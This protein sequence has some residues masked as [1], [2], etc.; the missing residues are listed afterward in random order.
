MIS[1]TKGKPH[2]PESGVKVYCPEAILS[3]TDGDQ[4]P[5]TPLS[6]VVGSTGATSPAQIGAG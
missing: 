5:V 3:T 4:E 1:I 2:C 6:E